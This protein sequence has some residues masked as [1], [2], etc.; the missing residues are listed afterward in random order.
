MGQTLS[1][2]VVS[3]NKGHS[4]IKDNVAEGCYAGYRTLKRHA[5]TQVY[6][7]MG[8]RRPSRR[9]SRLYQLLPLQRH[10]NLGHPSQWLLSASTPM[11]P[12]FLKFSAHNQMFPVCSRAPR[13]TGILVGRSWRYPD[14]RH[15][16]FQSA[17]VII[18]RMATMRPNLLHNKLGHMV[19]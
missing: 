14:V 3:V 15:H 9:W 1:V 18:R 2:Q 16:R 11:S 12:W 10:Y 8:L 6:C 7:I 4:F 19:D 5:A 17:C 13:G